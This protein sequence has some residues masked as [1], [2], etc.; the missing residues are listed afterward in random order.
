MYTFSIC[1]IYQY[2]EVY[3]A[4]SVCNLFPLMIMIV[5]SVVVKLMNT[6]L[7]DLKSGKLWVRF[8]G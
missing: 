5:I 8:L 4:T 2:F 7:L 3:N 6:R 1:Y